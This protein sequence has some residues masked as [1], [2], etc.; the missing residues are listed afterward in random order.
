MKDRT[1]QN[2]HNIFHIQVHKMVTMNMTIT[3]DMMK[4]M[5]MMIPKNRPMKMLM[6]KMMEK[7]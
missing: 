5:D 4:T 6:D 2:H 3:M 7:K 1:L